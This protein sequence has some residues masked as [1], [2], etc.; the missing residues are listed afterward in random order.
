MLFNLDGCTRCKTYDTYA[1]CKTCS[2]DEHK[3][4]TY[5]CPFITKEFYPV[6][7]R[8]YGYLQEKA[9]APVHQFCINNFINNSCSFSF[10]SLMKNLNITVPILGS[11]KDSVEESRSQIVTTNF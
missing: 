11:H 10:T 8:L 1:Y 7:L 4:H 9:I 6:K 2:L 3:N 5:G